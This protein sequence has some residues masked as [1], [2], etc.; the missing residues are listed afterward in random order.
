MRM[1]NHGTAATTPRGRDVLAADVDAGHARAVGHHASERAGAHFPAAAFDEGARRLGVHLVQ[2]AQRQRDRRRPSIGAEHLGEHAHEG[3][4]ERFV[5]RLI[6]RRERQRLPQPGRQ[7]L[8][9][10]ALVQPA[11]HGDVTVDR[12]RSGAR[13]L[14]PRRL[15]R[16]PHPQ[17]RQTVPPRHRRPRQHRAEQVQR[18]RQRRTLQHRPV[19]GPIQVGHAQ[20]R[21]PAHV[22]LGTDAAKKRERLRVAAKEHVLAVVDEL[23]GDAIGEGRRPSPELR[24]GLEYQHPAAGLGQRRGGRQTREAGADDDHVGGH[25]VMT[26]KSPT[27]AGDRGPARGGCAATSRP[28]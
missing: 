1:P 10:P 17:D 26:V 8:G 16:R 22:A 14:P 21:L 11:R 28:Q 19:A 6:E 12:Q 25:G 27:R 3:R 24:T 15:Q 13:E 9:L 20:R 23:A 7:L 4:R 5:W 2:R 18:R